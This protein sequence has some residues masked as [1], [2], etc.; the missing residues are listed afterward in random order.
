MLGITQHWSLFL[1]SVVSFTVD[2]WYTVV[3]MV[4]IILASIFV[5]AFVFVVVLSAKLVLVFSYFISLI[6]HIRI[7]L[8]FISFSIISPVISIVKLSKFPGFFL[9]ITSIILFWVSISFDI[10]FGIG[11]KSIPI[12]LIIELLIR[13]LWILIVVMPFLLHIYSKQ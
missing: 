3:L 7:L 8:P 4:L 11:F 9:I 12:A 2:V 10:L 5:I 13:I 6:G 1:L